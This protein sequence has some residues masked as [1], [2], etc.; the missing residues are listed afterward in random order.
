MRETLRTALL[1]EAF[2]MVVLTIV[3]QASPG[4]LLGMFSSDQQVLAFGTTFLTYTSWNFLASGIVFAC[5][6]L[7]QAMGNTW[8]TPCCAR[9]CGS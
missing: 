1:M 3:C 7:F 5:S 2:I 8:P 4:A 9:R 6:G